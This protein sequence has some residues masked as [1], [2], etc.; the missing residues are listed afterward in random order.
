MLD[1]TVQ[2]IGKTF[3]PPASAVKALSDISFITRTGEFLCIVGP[4]G[5]GKTTLLR[6]VGDLIPPTQGRVSIGDLSPR[7]ARKEN[8]F[9]WVFQTPV[10]L[11]W[12]NLIRNVTLPLEIQ[13]GRKSRDPE[14]LLKLV[15]L[16]GFEHHRPTELSGGMQ[17]RAALARALTFYPQILLMDEPFAAVDEFTRA[18]LNVELSRICRETELCVLFVT[19]SIAEAVFLADRVIVLSRRPGTIKAIVDV[20]LPRPRDNSIRSSDPFREIA[21]CIESIIS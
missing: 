7:D 10:L 12:R 17:H 6:I 2:E 8:V 9:S 5:C 19:H 18:M 20:P 21:Q 11:P 13:P 3:G 15:G 4:S 1:I 16:D 14:A